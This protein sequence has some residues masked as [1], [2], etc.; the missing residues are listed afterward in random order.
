MTDTSV[1]FN[2][3]TNSSDEGSLIPYPVLD[4]RNEEELAEESMLDGFNRSGGR[5]NDT[6]THNPLAVFNRTLARLG[7]EILWYVNKLPRALAVAYLRLAGVQRSLGQRAR[8]ELT[9]I[10]STAITS[11]YQ[12]PAGFEVRPDA[13]LLSSNDIDLTF[14]T[15][16]A[17]V[18]TPGNSSG[19][20]IAECTQVGEIGN[21]PA[22]VLTLFTVPY[23]NLSEVRNLEPAFGGSNPESLE[24][25]ESRA[26]EAIRRR[27]T[28]IV[29]SDYEQAAVD[30]LGSGSRAIAL[31]LIGADGITYQ[32]GSVHVFGVRSDQ[33]LPSEAE[34]ND[35]QARLSGLVPLGTTVYFTP[36]EFI[37]IEVKVIVQIFDGFN[38]EDVFDEMRGAL[39]AFL[40]PTTYAESDYVNL[41]DLKFLLRNVLGVRRVNSVV[42][43]GL[44]QDVLLPNAKSLPQLTG[45]YF[46]GFTP[47]QTLYTYAFG[48]DTSMTG[49]VPD[50]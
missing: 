38:P 26:L 4:P 49:E 31:P 39:Q 1:T 8:V 3:N 37:Q 14:V 48:E 11:S 13:T 30:F 16:E 15:L 33:S 25:V 45:G 41:N 10:L 28:L 50:V 35:I 24:Q 27:D 19:S 18:I 36:I 29:K 9:F 47:D 44:G 43:N 5:L 46:E 12:I 21:V 32:I 6:T 34:C 40:S 22:G 42:L 17:L 7:S 23:A 2:P 20:V